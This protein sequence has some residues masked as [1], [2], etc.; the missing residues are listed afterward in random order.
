MSKFSTTRQRAE[1]H[2]DGAQGLAALL[3]KV[4]TA[5]ELSAT[6]D[7]RYLARCINQAGFSWKVIDNKWPEFEE[8]F[9]RFDPEFSLRY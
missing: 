2:K 6:G 8:G 5:A 3:P 4:A 1:Q 9:H 7:D